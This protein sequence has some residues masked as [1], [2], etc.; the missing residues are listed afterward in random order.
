MKNRILFGLM[1]AA[2]IGLN[3]GCA[4]V[5]GA[6]NRGVK[7]SLGKVDMVALSEGIYFYN[8]ITTDIHEMTAKEQK[9][10]QKVEAFSKDAQVVHVSFAVNWRPVSARLPEMFR[11]KGPDYINVLM[12]QVVYQHLKEVAGQYQATDL[13]A[14]REAVRTTVKSK[15][16]AEMDGKGIEV[17][18]FAI[19]DIDYQPEFKEAV[20]AKVVAVQLADQAKNKTVQVR[21]EANQ[22]LISAQS[23][24]AAM[25][26]KA[27][28]LASNQGLVAYEALSVQRA[29]IEKWNGVL[30]TSMIGNTT[31][32]LNLNK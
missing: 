31:P 2:F 25:R 8:P 6:G 32:I 3:T 9:W 21:E 26:I 4:E 1:C 16:K 11:D 10:E 22:R 20:E 13:I 27:S 19:N 15:L 29:A 23:D 14:N 24:A 30:P 5:V 28:A 7:V 18:D 17:V 12:P